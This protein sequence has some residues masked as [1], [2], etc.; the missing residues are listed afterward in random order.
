M[1]AGPAVVARH[2]KPLRMRRGPD[3]ESLRQLRGSL[4]GLR[5][6]PLRR[7]LFASSPAP[8]QLFRVDGCD[9]V[10][11]RLRLRRLARQFLRFQPAGTPGQLSNPAEASQ[12]RTAKA[13]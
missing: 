5:P 8:N 11:D 9:F 6:L 10:A 12:D 2:S 1:P 7:A 4:N 13:V 3:L